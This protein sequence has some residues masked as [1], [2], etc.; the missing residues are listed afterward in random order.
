LVVPGQPGQKVSET[1]LN[2]QTGHSGIPMFPAMQEAQVGGL[3]SEAS[4]SQKQ[5]TLPKKHL[6]PKRAQMVERLPSKC[7][8]LTSNPVPPKD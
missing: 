7:E 1:C 6:K 5:E 8:A 3:Q 4:P 2:Q